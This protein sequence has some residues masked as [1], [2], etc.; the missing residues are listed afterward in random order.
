MPNSIAEIKQLIVAKQ[1]MAEK[2][3]TELPKV[4]KEVIDFATT[5]VQLDGKIS[6]EKD[7]TKKGLLEKEQNEVINKHKV[8]SLKYATMEKAE[9]GVQD[10]LKELQKQLADALL[11]VQN[12]GKARQAGIDMLEKEGKALKVFCEQAKKGAADAEQCSVQAEL[13]AKKGDDN[14]AQGARNNANNSVMRTIDA[15]REASKSIHLITDEMTKTQR[16]LK[17]ETFGVTN[18]DIA[19]HNGLTKQVQDKFKV[20]ELMASECPQF[21]KTAETAAAEATEFAN[22]VGVGVEMYD[23]M[24]DKALL[25]AEQQVGSIKD[26]MASKWGGYITNKGELFTRLDKQLASK[27]TDPAMRTGVEKAV[28][29]GQTYLEATL[30]KVNSLVSAMIDS[31]NKAT[32]R[33]PLEYKPTLKPKIDK[34]N[35]L[36]MQILGF[37]KKVKSDYDAT[38]IEFQKL[39]KA[40]S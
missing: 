31:C 18:A 33:V 1:K 4:K 6:K 15:A 26:I 12:Y 37:Q 7:K 24:L 22:A 27:P 3:K 5:K 29:Q 21:V 16:N 10:A 17:A 28:E 13:S 19:V 34:I 9:T 40:V 14:G 35:M 30:V 8:A 32:K 23:K 36:A 2:N 11:G 20:L 25:A 39:V 38:D